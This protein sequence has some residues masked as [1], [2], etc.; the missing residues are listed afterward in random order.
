MKKSL[1]MFFLLSSI[2]SI[3]SCKDDSEKIDE[4]VLVVIEEFIASNDFSGYFCVGDNV[5]ETFETCLSATL[6]DIDTNH[7]MTL[8]ISRFPC[9]AFIGTPYYHLNRMP[10]M[11]YRVGDKD[12]FVYSHTTDSVNVLFPQSV[13]SRKTVLEK[14][15]AYFIIEN[16][17]D[18]LM[19]QTYK[20]HHRD[21][22]LWIEKDSTF[23]L[24]QWL[25]PE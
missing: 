22:K 24:Y 14:E 6:F 21:K 13:Y 9:D 11:Y 5:C 18:R 1:I 4:E 7:Y 8:I 23:N 12:L 19:I 10:P 2:F 3:Y 15:K 20:Y 25:C 17:D 16:I